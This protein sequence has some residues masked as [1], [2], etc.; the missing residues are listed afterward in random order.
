MVI[1]ILRDTVW[2]LNHALMFRSLYAT[3]PKVELRKDV[4]NFGSAAVS[5]T[6]RN[7]DTKREYTFRTAG[8]SSMRI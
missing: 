2:I 4:A 6:V 5:D 1:A 7:D 8:M 3:S